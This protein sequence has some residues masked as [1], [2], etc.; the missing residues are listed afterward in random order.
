L[1]TVPKFV[2]HLDE[3]GEL[4]LWP[5][6][7]ELPSQADPAHPA[8]PS[9]Q[10]ANIRQG[11][12]WWQANPLHENDA[13]PAAPDTV[14]YGGKAIPTR[15]RER[16]LRIK[17]RID[18][19]ATGARVRFLDRDGA[20]I[21]LRR[22]LDTASP[23]V[24]EVTCELS[25]GESGVKT[26]KAD[27]FFRHTVTNQIHVPESVN[28]F[29]P[30]YILILSEQTDPPIVDAFPG[31]LCGMQTAL[32]D[33][34]RKNH[35]GQERGTFLGEIEDKNIVSFKHSPT[36][37]PV[38]L[39][40]TETQ[41][42]RMLAY[43][44]VSQER[45][46]DSTQAGGPDNPAVLKPQM[47]MWMAEAQVVGLDPL[48]LQDLQ[49]RA[50]YISYFD[51]H[52][53]PATTPLNFD[54]TWRLELKWPG[55]DNS[56]SQ[57][58]PGSGNEI[59][60]P[61]Q[62]Y[63]SQYPPDADGS[64]TQRVE[65]NFNA[66]GKLCDADGIALTLGDDGSVP[67]AFTEEQAAAAFPV[68][69]RRAP[70]V[71]TNVNRP[72]GRHAGAV[73]KPSLLIEWQPAI[74]DGDLEIIRGGDGE[75]KALSAKV[76]NQRLHVWSAPE[77]PDDPDNP[78]APGEPDMRMPTFRVRSRTDGAVT[79]GDR[80]PRPQAE[81]LINALVAKYFNDP[82]HNQSH[83]T[84]LSLAC[85]QA[86]ARAI[87]DHENRGSR[88]YYRQ[89]DERAS[90]RWAWQRQISGNPP[91]VSHFYF[92]NE[93]GMPLFGPPHGYGFGQLDDAPASDDQVW[94]FVENIREAVRRIF[95]QYGAGAYSYLT[96]AIISSSA[97][98]L[99]TARETVKRGS[100]PAGAAGTAQYNAAHATAI[101]NAA[102][103]GQEFLN[104]AGQRKRAIYQR[105][106]V[107]RYNGGREFKYEQ[108]N[109]QWQWVVHTNITSTDRQPYPNLVLHT[110]VGEPGPTVFDQA[111][112]FGPET[113][114]P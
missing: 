104:L 97:T 66:G 63:S 78:D 1:V 111:G 82:A 11:A 105:E 84:T 49:L 24:Q 77:I 79:A 21:P 4:K 92:G 23:E 93:S 38:G 13:S 6:M 37:A 95:E 57:F 27:V 55:P 58:G 35:N 36:A 75:L 74:K 34:F 20:A 29:G 30:A 16:G 2:I 8:K 44:I 87:F 81:T 106:L 31:H 88:A 65:L 64:F 10:T 18:G 86:T 103:A 48:D 68:A 69:G 70:K 32:V 107:R 114:N 39:I 17:G 91:T 99:E 101:A 52:E 40:S 96:T 9:Y 98:K 109:S 112:E 56:T 53:K 25:A 62:S 94:S 51:L 83:V 110:A 7:W 80:I 59:Q 46:L 54:V 76:Y 71:V 28:H 113:A 67:H 26:F 15:P 100:Y 22:E 72:W 50:Y 102:A 14:T 47:P 85:W 3:P 89:Y 42:R 108:A 12:D 90:G 41:A 45:L 33:D 60:R 61:N 19:R 73:E 5:L 43:E